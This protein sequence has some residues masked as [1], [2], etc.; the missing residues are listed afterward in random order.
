MLATPGV[1]SKTPAP[2]RWACGELGRRKQTRQPL[3]SCVPLGA[4]PTAFCGPLAFV[5]GWLP[6]GG[7]LTHLSIEP[8]PPGGEDVLAEPGPAPTAAL[9]GG[10]IQDLHVRVA[11]HPVH[12]EVGRLPRPARLGAA[13]ACGNKWERVHEHRGRAGGAG[14]TR[15]HARLQAGGTTRHLAFRFWPGQRCLSA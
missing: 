9:P 4:D 5:A 7:A 13:H 8:R 3:V 1:T 15:G 14:Q 11:R 12:A 2:S 10:G 6:R